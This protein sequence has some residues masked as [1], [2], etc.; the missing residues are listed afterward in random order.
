M[1][2]LNL[3]Q[4]SVPKVLLQFA[5]PF[6]V[7]NILQALYGGAD[8]FVVGQY[9]DSAGVAAV[10][11]GSQVMQTITGII[12][13]I[14]T[15]TTVLIAI[16]TGAKDN[17]KVASTIGSS[18]WLF[19]IT[20]IILTLLMILLHNQIAE[21]MHTPTEAMSDTKSYI[22]VCS[23]GILFIIG[24]NVVC[25]ILRGL[26]DSKTPLYFIALACIINIVL[27][28]ILVG[29]F[30]LGATGAAIATVTAQ[31]VSFA[32]ALCFLHRKGFHFE[33]TRRDIRLNGVLSKRI[34]TL[35]AP[36]AL[37][38]ALI[39]VS[40]LIITVIVNQMGVIASASLG[41]VEKIIVFA[42]LPPMAISSAVATMTAQN[43]GAGL[44]R[45][46]NQC[47]LSGIGLAL[48][49]GVTVCLYSQFLPETLTAFFSKDPAV[50]SMAAE[51]LKGYSI[52]CV[53]VSFVFC[54]NSYFSGQGNSLFPMIHSLIATFLFRIPLSYWFSQIDSSSLFIMGFAPPLST[55]VSLLI[56][57]WYLR[58][59][60]DKR[61][62]THPCYSQPS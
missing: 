23:T 12:L 11:I 4:G 57:I 27:D 61:S 44:I 8:L 34:L 22:L 13:G 52:D 35:G 36:I 38:D 31:G 10:A 37:Q 33:F 20:G 18:I 25:G 2:E 58:Y 24:Y 54:I 7:A 59:T 49:F 5:V 56:C 26:G 47:L 32:T 40:F 1:K 45:R 29:Y 28:F 30:H 48:I 17:R 55:I 46:M 53:I 16:A 3:T 43:Y 50:I 60:K 19:S 6:L 9:D 62:T 15:G 41:V 14:T 51:Y 39:N 21:W 42:M